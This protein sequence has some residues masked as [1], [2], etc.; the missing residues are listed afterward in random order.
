MY[1][2]GEI[3]NIVSPSSTTETSAKTHQRL[4]PGPW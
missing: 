3:G 2:T 1:P 4:Q